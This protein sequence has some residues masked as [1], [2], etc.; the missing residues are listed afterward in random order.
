[1]PVKQFE[2][3][4]LVVVEKLGRRW[5]GALNPR[6]LSW[7]GF[8]ARLGLGIIMLAHGVQKLGAF[9]GAGWEGTIN[10]F[11]TQLGIPPILGGLVILTEAVGGALLIVGLFARAAALAVAIEMLVAAIKVHIPN[12]FFLNW[13]VT[14]GKGHGFEMN[15]ALMALALTVLIDGAGR[16]A[17]DTALADKLDK[18]V[19]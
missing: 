2:R 12:G 15:L 3:E 13:Y 6:S 10:T 4:Q 7:G 16:L 11:Q 17:A 18:E 5:L 14:P 9:G 19:E 1:M 8:V